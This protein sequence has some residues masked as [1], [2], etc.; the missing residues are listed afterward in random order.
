MFIDETTTIT[1]ASLSL[2]KVTETEEGDQRKTLAGSLET[3]SRPHKQGTSDES[4]NSKRIEEPAKAVFTVGGDKYKV[5]SGRDGD[6]EL[7][8]SH[9]DRLHALGCLGEGVLERGDGGEDLADADENV[10]ARD[11][12]D[13]DGRGEWVALGVRA[14]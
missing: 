14:F 5:P 11:D 12:P 1:T 10:R 13:V 7:G 2:V 3:N 8:D 6:L 9:D 4:S